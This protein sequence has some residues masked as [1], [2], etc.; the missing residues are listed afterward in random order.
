MIQTCYLPKHERARDRDDSRFGEQ[1]FPVFEIENPKRIVQN[2]TY[3]K[4]QNVYG[5]LGL[6]ESTD[7]LLRHSQAE[8]LQARIDFRFRRLVCSIGRVSH[9]MITRRAIRTL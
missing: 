7:R 9:K 4:S 3:D 5:S 8:G 6:A 1:N 2:G